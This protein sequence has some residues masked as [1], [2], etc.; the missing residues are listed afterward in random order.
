MKTVIL[1]G[2]LGNQLFEYVFSQYLKTT[3]DNDIRFHFRKYGNHYGLELP[4]WFDITLKPAPFFISMYI[5]IIDKLHSMSLIKDKGF[6]RKNN[7]NCC[8][9]NIYDDY[10]ANKYYQQTGIPQFRSN[11]PLNDKNKSILRLI[12]SGPCAS[13]HVRR[14]DYLKPQNIGLFENICDSDYYSQAIRYI[15]SAEPQCRFLIFSDD[16]EW[17]KENL[18]LDNPIFIDW[19]R[20]EESPLDMFLMSKCDFNI[21]A[22]S[23]FSYWGARLNVKP[24][25]VIYPMNWL[26]PPRNLPDI[27]P[28]EWIGL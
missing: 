8:K 15:Q 4:R 3:F 12:N 7:I 23:T 16:M 14:G 6:V 22:N 21:I 27:F 1:Q 18:N 24:R 11:I 19:N 17:C 13:L 28:D 2:G 25:K 10:W 20:D 5:K 9:S 26:C